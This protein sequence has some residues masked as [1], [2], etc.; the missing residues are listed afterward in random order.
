MWIGIKTTINLNVLS[1]QFAAMIRYY[2]S[3]RGLKVIFL[4]IIAM[5]LQRATAQYQVHQSLE[6]RWQL[7]DVKRNHEAPLSKLVLFNRSGEDISC[8]GWS[9]WFNFMRNIDPES[10]SEG[11]AIAHRN[12]DLYQLSFVDSVRVIPAGDS[13]T[14]KFATIGSLPNFT[15]GPSG[16]YITYAK[17]GMPAFNL[18]PIT[19]VTRSFVRSAAELAAQYRSNERSQKT[20]EQLILPQP[21]SIKKSVGAFLL[22]TGESLYADTIFN[23]EATQLTD[24]LAKY[25]G[26]SL[27]RVKEGDL[28][29]R[30][31]ITLRYSDAV[32][33]EAYQLVINEEGIAVVSGTAEGAFYAIQSLKSLLEVRYWGQNAGQVKLPCLEVDDKPRFGYRGVMIDVS[34]NFHPKES[35]FRILDILSM[36]KL[37]TLHLHLNDDEGW[38][39]QI[40]SLPEL[41]EIGSVRDAR[42]NEFV[43]L[44][45]SYGSGAIAPQRAFYTVED[46][47]E[48]LRYAADRHVTVIPEL[49]TPGHARA[50]IK[51]MEARYKKYVSR[52][53]KQE[54]EKFLLSD[55][56]DRSV[57]SS[58]QNWTDNVMNVAL[59]S[60]YT[61]I[62]TVIDEI[63][64]MYDMAG[65]KLQKIHLG[66]D[67]VPAGAWEKSPKI[68]GMMDSL[69]IAT[70]HGVWPYYIQ[71]IAG[72][73]QSK[74]LQLAGWEEMGMAND[75]KGMKVNPQMVSQRI[76]VDVWNNLIG[77]G[78]EDLAYK[79]A[80]AGYQ[81][82]F[83]SA[84]NF[85]MD[86]AWSNHFD[87]PGHNWAGYTSI[88]KS[89]SLIPENY[90][91]NIHQYDG[92][93]QL[94][95][96]YFASKEK[97]TPQGKMNLIGL[98]GA[99]WS[100]K[101]TK[102]ERM[103]YM[104][105]PRMFALAEKAWSPVR[106]WEEGT[107]FNQEAFETDFTAF[108]DKVGCEELKKLDILNDGYAYRLPAIG[109]QIS[110]GQI[111]CNTEYPG[112][113]VYYTDNG[114]EPT[115]DSNK[116][117]GPVPIQG[118]SV[119]TFR[120][121]TQQGRKGNPV[122]VEH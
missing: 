42:Y 6:A 7:I 111:Y 120:I 70:V 35:I 116:Y 86:L 69:G 56:D 21:S 33:G 102:G 45:P 99:L 55:F 31:A 30:A 10:V 48:I 9:L 85:Y 59:P 1:I 51:S 104:L 5:G 87:E 39:L 94:P 71:K 112:F 57:Y 53:D 26:I 98:K 77:D 83:T 64:S 32:D 66:G 62:G 44:Q 95:A 103:E 67:E 19:V 54:A 68:R 72:L 23:K 25:A 8:R 38:R 84:S 49:E 47:V 46:F 109:V 106:T 108:M 20:P 4:G 14:V 34:R 122:R 11:Y 52:G 40:P 78:Q 119:Y 100:E 37:N 18:D 115:L 65:L 58:A 76:Q 118:S 29:R 90:F 105:F 81:V 50:A 89:Y 82:V 60:T 28:A 12:G 117:H 41:T 92:S 16:L 121:I 75:G 107:R 27:K 61:F 63:K 88:R 101:I 17:P 73:C 15:D 2:F 79:L 22:Q 24:F 110:N 80:N 93:K 91:L 113:D 97:L 96:A 43:S 13:I 114:T 74:G 3:K 36:Y